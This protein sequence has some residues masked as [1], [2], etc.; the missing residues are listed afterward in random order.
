VTDGAA[1]GLRERKKLDTRMALTDAAL[2]L[3]FERGLENVT[4]EEIAARVGV[5]LRTFTNYFTNKY[6]AVA[7]RQVQRVRHSL[8]A[9]RQRPGDEPL[10]TSITEAVLEPFEA[11]GADEWVPTKRQLAETAKIIQSPEA[12]LAV[13]KEVF[14]DWVAVIAE[15][16]GTD[17]VRDMYPRLVAAV[18][19]AVVEAAID[20]YVHADPPVAPAGLLRRGFSEVVAGL[21]PPP[22]GNATAQPVDIF[23]TSG[24]SDVQ[25]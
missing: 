1:L 16:T 10:W 23:P 11:A 12:R 19:R 3:T 8:T 9:L 13:S 6:E 25:R 24:E 22:A 14:A 7:Y 20:A 4:R 21:K 2:N 18:I 15:R 17:P 5:S